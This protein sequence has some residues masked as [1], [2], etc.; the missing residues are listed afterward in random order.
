MSIMKKLI[1]ILAA[2][3]FFDIG[4]YAQRSGRSSE[5]SSSRKES[6]AVKPSSSRSNSSATRSS[7]SRSSNVSSSS[8]RS[9]AVSPSR[10]SSRSSSSNSVKRSSTPSRSSTYSQSPRSSSSRTKG[11]SSGSRSSSTQKSSGVTNSRNSSSNTRSYR[12][13]DNGRSNSSR[14]SAVNRSSSRSSQERGNSISN[15]NGDRRYRDNGNKFGNNGVRTRTHWQDRS[16]TYQRNPDNRRNYRTNPKRT[17][18]TRRSPAKRTNVRR[19]ERNTPRGVVVETRGTTYMKNVN[20]VR[21]TRVVNY[22]VVQPRPI[23]YRRV[24][25]VYRAPRRFNFFWSVNVYNDFCNF[26]PHV[27]QWH[28]RTGA[29]I[30]TVSAYDAMF[31]IGEVKRVYGEVQEVFYSRED[32]AYYLYIGARFPYHDFSIVI[33]GRDYRRHNFPPIDRL[34]LQHVWAMGLIT[35]YEDRPEIVVKKPYQLGIY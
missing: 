10:S 11:Y 4:A 21:N 26:Y 13:S 8:S 6:S 9:K 15:N 1:L 27:T 33:P 2:L 32:D 23:E 29:R 20:I 3:F 35:A 31:F 28:Y 18:V 7:G 16:Q 19:V 17:E 34:N 24:H 25:F 14:S 22:H 30:N 12:S 5:R